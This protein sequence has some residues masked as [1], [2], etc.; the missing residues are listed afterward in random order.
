MTEHGIAKALEVWTLQ[1]LLNISIMLGILV[2]GLALVQGYY[3]SLEKHLSLR[4]SI[5]LWRILTVVLVDVLLAVVVI[6]GYVVLNPDILADIKVAVPFYP[7]T[8]ILFGMALVLRLFHGGHDPRSKNFLRAIYLM[9][10]ASVINIVG[11]TFVAEAPSGEYL[12]THPSPFWD[13]V[14]NHLRS[15]ADPSGL[16][17]TQIT[18]YICFPLLMGVFV[19]GFLAA[20]RQLRDSKGE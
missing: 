17:L 15:N 20:L 12:T 8:T 3:R 2:C 7:I 5:E 6:V 11:F 18:F 19:W 13:Y 10:V 14:K 9:F 4:V 1:N 16:E